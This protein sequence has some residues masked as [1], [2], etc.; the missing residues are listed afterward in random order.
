MN[1]LKSLAKRLFRTAV[2]L[3]LVFPVRFYYRRKLLI[4]FYHGV[5]N[6][7]CRQPR[8]QDGRH[9]DT[10]KFRLQMEY[11]ARKYH[12]ISLSDAVRLLAA[13]KKLP[14]NPVVVTFDDGYH[15]NLDDMYPVVARLGIPVTIFCSTD[16]ARR[17]RDYLSWEE[18]VFLHEQGIA[19]GSHTVTHPHLTR[20]SKEEARNELSGSKEELESRL[21]S[22]V[23][24]FSYPYGENDDAVRRL[25][26]EAGYKAACT[27]CYGANDCTTNLFA[28]KRIA[29][30]DRYSFEF[31]TAALFPGVFSLVRRFFAG[32]RKAAV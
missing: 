7:V 14:G 4:L 5:S 21:K 30:N 12:V 24:F 26:R 20:I 15:N 25:A 2:A 32:A 1:L 31:F 8:H 19:F 13:G 9:V 22:P 18:M 6:D 27:V 17:G 11:I 10:G 29:V 16:F 3:D 28:L 23:D